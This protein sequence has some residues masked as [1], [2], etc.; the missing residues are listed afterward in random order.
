MSRHRR[1]WVIE[2]RGRVI[3]VRGWQVADLLRR[4]GMKPIYSAS[5]RGWVLDETRLPDVVALAEWQNIGVR[6]VE[7]A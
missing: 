4:A 1:H 2:T 5:A 3:L 6:F 7:A